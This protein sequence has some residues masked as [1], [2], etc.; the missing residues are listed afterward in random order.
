MH[1][2][3]LLAPIYFYKALFTLHVYCPCQGVKTAAVSGFRS[4]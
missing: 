4:I 1:E 3:Y 2:N